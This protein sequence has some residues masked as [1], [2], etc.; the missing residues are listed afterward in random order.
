MNQSTNTS[1][2]SKTVESSKLQILPDLIPGIVFDIDLD[3]LQIN[4]VN[5]ELTNL[6]G[7]TIEEVL[8][9]DFEVLGSFVH[10]EDL[11]Q[12]ILSIADFPSG[13]IS[14][15]DLR[16]LHKNGY[17]RWFSSRYV[18]TI[19]E[20]ARKSRHL[21]GVSLDITE[22]KQIELSLQE[23]QDFIE[24]V[25]NTVPNT[26]FVYNLVEKRITYSNHNFAKLGYTPEQAKEL[27]NKS[28]FELIHPDDVDNAYKDFQQ[29]VFSN[30][31]DVLIGEYRMRT[32]QGEWHWYSIN[33]VIFS[34]NELGEP[35][36]FIGTSQ[37]ISHRK[38][39]ELELEQQSVFAMH[40]LNLMGQ[41]LVINNDQGYITYVNPAAV[42]IFGYKNAE[43]VI[44]KKIEDF[45]PSDQ[46]QIV[47]NNRATRQ[48]GLSV[49]SEIRGLKA[50]GS[51][52]DLLISGVPYYLNGQM[53]GAITT[54]SNLT[55]RK[56]TELELHNQR[57]FAVQVLN[58][59]GQGLVISN[60]DGNFEYINPSAVKMFGYSS[61]D[62]LFGKKI[63][64]FAVPE[65]REIVEHHRDLRDKGK[66][67]NYE[68]R[69]LTRDGS[70][71]D[72]LVTGVP[73]YQHG[74]RVGSIAVLTDVTERKRIEKELR[75][76]KAF[77]ETQFNASP[78]GVVA[79]SDKREW[80]YMN[81]TFIQ[82]W[83][84]PADLVKKMNRL[85]ALKYV[86]QF[87]V[88][89][90]KFMAS[91][92]YFYSN[93]SA[94]GTDE[95]EL[96]DG[97][98]L[99]RY[100]QSLFTVEHDFLG[101][102]WF[103]TDVTGRKAEENR[104]LKEN[105][106]LNAL[107]DISLALI[108][109]LNIDDLLYSI[110]EKA[111]Q[112]LNCDRVTVFS[113]NEAKTALIFKYGIGISEAILG[114]EFGRGIGLAGKVW[115]YAK[116]VVIE[117]YYDQINKPAFVDLISYPTYAV[118]GLPL[119][120]NDEVI[121]VLGFLHSDPDRQF[122]AYEIEIVERLA[123]LASLALQNAHMF[124]Q[125]NFEVAER[126]KAETAL[127]ESKQLYQI[128]FEETEKQAREL[129]LLHL[130]RTALAD[131]TDV[132]SLVRTAVETIADVLGYSRVSICFVEETELVLQ[133][134]V[135]YIKMPDRY[136][137]SLGI[138]SEVLASGL[139]L[140]VEDVSTHP[141][142][143]GTTEGIVSQICVPLFD[144]SKP[145]GVLNLESINGQK[146]YHTDLNLMITLA[147]HLDQ[148]LERARLYT[149]LV[150]T[151]EKALESS[152]LKSEF[153]ANM[154][155]EIRT[156]MNGIIGTLDLLANTYLT[157]DQQELINISRQSSS[158]LLTLIDDILDLSKIEAGKLTLENIAFK[159]S[160]LLAESIRLMTPQAQEKNLLLSQADAV[161]TDW[162]VVGDPL[163]LR[164][165]LLN[166]L[167]NAI[168]FTE[169]G[170]VQV[171]LGLV[172]AGSE[173]QKWRFEVEDSGIGIS[174]YHQEML[175]QPFNQA[176]SS[177]T[178]KY[179]GTGLGLAISR[180]LVE[181]MGG[182]IGVTSEVGAGSLF[183][184]EVEL[185]V[186]GRVTA[187]EWESQH[188]PENRQTGSLPSYR[189][190]LVEDNPT[191]QRLAALQLKRLGAE[192]EVVSDGF[193]AL[194]ELS[195][196]CYDLVLMDCQ[197]PGIDGYETTRLIRLLEN[198]QKLQVKGE[199][200]PVIAM[201]ASAMPGDR[202]RCLEAGMN[203]YVTKPLTLQSLES[204]LLKWLADIKIGDE[205]EIKFETK[206]DEKATDLILNYQVLDELRY[207]QGYEDV[208]VV[209]ETIDI[210]IEDSGAALEGLLKA[211]ENKDANRI[212]H[213][214]HYL[215]SS[216]ANL[217]S[218]QFSTL[219]KELEI[220]GLK[221]D[222]TGI[223]QFSPIISLYYRQF[224]S[225]LKN[226]S[227]EIGLTRFG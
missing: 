15:L 85:D 98:V 77:L 161:E 116:T 93:P 106:Y 61:A 215:K 130:V 168:K 65:F 117:N 44:G 111:Y 155:H 51:Q 158:L 203:D 167:S 210:F 5:S 227:A 115:E 156:P 183:W 214:T 43:D 104:L 86:E 186:V 218:K 176:D 12:L 205:E 87:L 73:Y 69:G 131:A 175:F 213:Y 198:E 177:T 82:I 160:E 89:P 126:R 129:E 172:E 174:P 118:L 163:R 138:S 212:T 81:Q 219:C 188:K 66:S 123:R 164:Q 13:Q 95:I 54:F 34:R 220:R 32:A 68:L 148:A 107:H 137:V 179:G 74:Q 10:P 16:L 67:S 225:A 30:G 28:I 144:Q 194:T 182:E 166:L 36:S 207:I 197:M 200:L 70:E 149:E 91:V 120:N 42:E 222:L 184:F 140:L 206:V 92:D 76:Q 2:H 7:Y 37:D 103:F 132:T 31:D 121:G 180:R 3:N 119:L 191:N 45:I 224:V 208:T 153:L 136:P 134:Q 17:Y 209:L 9:V 33:A 108:N 41:G 48:A 204:I 142:F 114:K 226:Y 109:R 127:Q 171:R 19:S 211:I 49:R 64:D 189:V 154:S 199:K 38:K 11:P 29:V 71:I 96:K 202:E 105:Q 145:V 4:Y 26:I 201:T 190:L 62:E 110:V 169:Q 135:G 133:H 75:F 216:S 57:D 47:R 181:L 157:S 8:N 55:E 195:E 94:T 53:V 84:F 162:V 88:D 90:V 35:L 141:K 187:E 6:L 173:R 18:F 150:T 27:V 52:I 196:D 83:Q 100:T 124:E 21:F 151:R 113:L 25:T 23:K 165:V 159:P 125:L 56:K 58:L 147:K 221:A 122:T 79:I 20:D 101:R 46:Q 50:D 143:L 97:R 102:V 146:L 24:K 40:V 178:R 72:I 112:I 170:K 152:R 78:V 63:E 223:D 1:N 39:I 60:Q 59:M 14:E 185:A 139:P 22:R 128:L 80:L 217:G 99:E 192:V 193:K